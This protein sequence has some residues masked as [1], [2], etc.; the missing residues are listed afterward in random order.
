MISLAAL[1][2]LRFAGHDRRTQTAAR[3]AIAALGVAAIAYQH[4]MDYDLRSRC[5]LIPEHSPRI[6]LIGRDGSAPEVVTVDPSRAAGIL[7]AAAGLA[8][9]TGIGWE[10]GE[11]RLVPAPKLV[12][13]IKR[14]RKVSAQV[15][16]SE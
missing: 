7:Q 10:S 5:L 15:Q 16:P 11:I 4:D 12:E 3:T 8:E 14:S 1:R 9:E 2:R 6:E 13:L